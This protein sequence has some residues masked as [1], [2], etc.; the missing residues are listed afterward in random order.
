MSIPTFIG[1][2]V[3]KVFSAALSPE[4]LSLS[5]E[6][7]G[8][9]AKARAVL[10]ST[11]A[12]K[13]PAKSL[14]P[15]IIR[16]HA[17]LDGTSKEVSGGSWTKSR[18]RAHRS[19]SPAAYPWPSRCLEPRPPSRQDGRHCREL[20]SHL[21]ALPHRLRS[22]SRARR[23][24]QPRGR[25]PTFTI[26]ESRADIHVPQDIDEIEENGLGAFVQFILKLNEQTFRPLFLRTYD[27]AVID[28]ADEEDAV[29]SLTARR[30]VLYKLVDRLLT[31][32][33]VSRERP[34]RSCELQLTYPFS[35]RPSSYLTSRSCSTKPS[36]CSSRSPRASSRTLPSGRRSPRRS[37]R[38]ST[39]TRPVRHSPVTCNLTRLTFSPS[40][41]FWTPLRLAKLSTPIAN[42]LEAPQHL[43]SSLIASHYHSLLSAYA[44]AL[45][46]HEN[47][48]KA[49]NSSLL[50][51]TRSDDLRVKR[52]ALEALDQV[53]ESL[54]DG[55]L[56]LVP[57]T[58][59]FLAE[60]M[61]EGEG[62]V[63]SATRVL[64]KRIEEHLGES[65]SSYLES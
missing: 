38:P 7:H 64:V 36:S 56:S 34:T 23:V 2:Q 46:P 5:E 58:T 14:Y 12:K 8:A 10:L 40:A 20:P 54:G 61:E 35:C 26:P 31:Q 41:G 16:L 33:R 43:T 17:S 3:D 18:A 6:K 39:T 51:L 47:H 22:P 11:A 24:A 49:F 48:L 28:L 1:A 45:L 29:A 62:G 63:E 15:A 21:Q 4:I 52:G 42:Q 30:V 25:L 65:L 59:P 60:T 37:P 55:M 53:W 57:E 13:L 44:Q 27:W 32:L 19:S 50:M 9:A